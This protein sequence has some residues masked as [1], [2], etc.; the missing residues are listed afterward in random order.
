[1]IYS[2][3]P[4][5]IKEITFSQ[6][7]ELLKPSGKIILEGFSKKHVEYQKK[8]PGIG[9]PPDVNMLYSVDEIRCF[10][11]EITFL[12]LSEEEIRLNEGNSHNGVG[13]VIRMVGVKG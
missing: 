6:L 10:L 7:T 12:K 13:S 8:N 3:V 9:G 1:M 4:L 11:P 5:P 2:H